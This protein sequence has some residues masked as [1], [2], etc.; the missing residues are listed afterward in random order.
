MKLLLVLEQRFYI[1]AQKKIYCERVVDYNFLT[2]Y[3]RVFDEV[4]ICARTVKVDDNFKGKLR[5]DGKNIKILELPDFKGSL[6]II[7]KFFQ[8]QRI[9]KNNLYKYDAVIMRAPTPISLIAL[10]PI[11]KEKK[12]FAVEFANN[13]T[14]MFNKE[15]SD[16]IF[17]SIIKNIFV[18]HGKK[19]CKYANG[20]SYVTERILQQQYPCIALNSDKGEQYFTTNYS[21]ISINKSDFYK[22]EIIKKKNVFT[23]CHVAFMDK[24]SKGH[25]EVIEVADRL[26]RKGYNIKVRFIGSG[27]LEQRFKKKI[28]ELDLKEYFEFIG[29]L[30]SYKEIQNYLKESDLFLFPS[31]SEGLPRVLIEAMANSLPCISTPLDG[32]L[33]LLPEEYLIHYK[34]ID[35]IVNVTEKFINNEEL[36]LLEGKRNYEKALEYENERLT[37][38]RDEFYEKLKKLGEKNVTKAKRYD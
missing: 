5:V 11:R 20:V 29:Q 9:I 30:D 35:K 6:G 2:R 19:I 26:I 38:K 33:E 12:I 1:T 16:S 32:M 23:I 18:N 37:Q 4:C 7:K 17:A 27:T 3:L 14:T 24:I 25:M 10:S 21:T 13:P 31:R 34:E 22:K 15:T 8:C 28:E 36:C